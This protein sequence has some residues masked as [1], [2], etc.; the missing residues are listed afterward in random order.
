MRARFSWLR[1]MMRR[2]ITA[3]GAVVAVLTMVTILIA[4][5]TGT[6]TRVSCCVWLLGDHRAHVL[7][8]RALAAATGPDG[9]VYTISL[10]VF[11]PPGSPPYWAISGMAPLHRQV[12]R[13]WGVYCDNL[14]E[15]VY[16]VAQ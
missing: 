2:P 12:I 9:R 14:Y 7:C 15:N 11:N 16:T 10:V 13:L 3:L 6:Q 8:S 5:R 1:P 4:L